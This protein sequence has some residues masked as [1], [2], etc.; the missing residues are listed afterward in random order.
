[1]DLDECFRK[2]LIKRTK[3]SKEL[4]QSLLEMSD[5]KEKTV[6]AAAINEFNVS[7]FVSLAYDALREVL[8]ALCVF[9]GYKVLSHICI[10][11]LLKKS[12]EDFD[13]NTFDRLRYVRNSINYYGIKVELPQGKELISKIFAM[14]ENL[15]ERYLKDF[16]NAPS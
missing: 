8:E 13:Y 11:E 1:M 15:I 4:I 10:G 9:K 6:R 5:I 3:I 2:G 7:A 14:K 16:L 12:L